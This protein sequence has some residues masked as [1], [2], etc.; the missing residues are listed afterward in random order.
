M[1]TATTSTTSVPGSRQLHVIE[2]LDDRREMYVAL[3]RLHPVRRV[4]FLR[5]CARHAR[6]VGVE[7]APDGLPPAGGFPFIDELDYRRKIKE[8]MRCDR[9]DDRLT[10]SVYMDILSLA[11]QYVFDVAAASVELERW[12]RKPH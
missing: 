5:W 9:G 12:A 10:A 3:A 4:A 6:L 8:A 11:N 7:P 2:T 1:S